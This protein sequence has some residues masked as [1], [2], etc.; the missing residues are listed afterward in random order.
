[1]F[2][3]ALF[4]AATLVL[5]QQALSR[6]RLGRARFILAAAPVAS[7]F[8]LT[9]CF[10]GSSLTTVVFLA[11][12]AVYG[13]VEWAATRHL[14]FLIYFSLG[15][16]LLTWMRFE[17][18]LWLVPVFLLLLLDIFTS[19]FEW[20]RKEAALILA[21]LP[22]AY[23]AGL[24]FLMNWLIMGDPL[25]FVRSILGE[26][27]VLG[28]M[29]APLSLLRLHFAAIGFAGFVFLV[30][31]FRRDR[32]GVYTGLLALSP[33]VPAFLLWQR[34]VLWD[35]KTILFC[36]FPFCIIAVGYELG[37]LRALPAK[38]R[39]AVTVLP[40]AIAI[41]SSLGEGGAW[42][43]R[44]VGEAD[45]VLADRKILLPRI[46]RHVLHKSRFV[47]VY[48]CGYDSFLLL[49][50]RGRGVFLHAMDFSFDKAKDDYPGHAL[51]VLLRRP[52]G[53]AATESVHWKF[54]RLFDLGG[55]ST[56]YDSDW[57]DWRLFEIIQAP[58]EEEVGHSRV[59]DDERAVVAGTPPS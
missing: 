40:L 9:A 20:R 37:Q 39:Y 10:D 18:G 25:Y 43:R 4:G 12:L 27:I 24:W 49:G 29:A 59:A 1:L 8:Y 21:L 31:L 33:L 28:D 7:S 38:I 48:V 19:R 23:A 57:G 45:T 30:A 2:V 52:R 54:D 16:A 42:T 51:Y 14:R 26:G 17:M 34:G 53:R 22:A 6:W 50:R 58:T 55:R 15:T 11:A 36:L 46:E 56:L 3:S 41:S 13:L 5:L 44:R 32:A 47:K 35:P